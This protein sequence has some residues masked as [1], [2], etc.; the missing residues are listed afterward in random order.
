M[1]A[2]DREQ[3]FA[4]VRT[5]LFGGTMTASEVAGV[6]AILAAW[7]ASAGP[8]PRFV[9][10]SLATAFHETAMTMQPI[11]EIGRGEGRPYGR[12]AGPDGQIY[13]GRGFVQLT[14]LA[15]Y[16]KVGS[17]I[18]NDLVDNPDLALKPDIAAE[19]LTHGMVGGWFTGRKLGDYFAGA[20]SDWVDAR[21]IINGVDK[22]ALIAGYALH[23]LHA[24]EG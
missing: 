11:E 21:R 14:W 12:P 17:L 3:F 18:G 24:I 23:F 10:Y 19:I 2:P 15:N 13:F 6:N 16:Q 22:A 1:I 9:A 7:D 20:R 4:R 5:Q 8:D